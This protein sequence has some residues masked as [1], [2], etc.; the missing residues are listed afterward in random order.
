MEY[1]NYHH[2]RVFWTVVQ[3]GGVTR[4]S[5]KLHVS[6][7]TVTAQIRSLEDALGQKLFK[8]SGRNLLLT[9]TGR[10]VY[11]YAD[12]MVGL[13]Q[14]LLDTV[15][16]QLPGHR[17]RLTVGVAMVVP[18]L[19]AYRVLEPVLKLTE[20]VRVECL[21]DTPERLLAELAV[22]RLDLVLADA[23]VG[24]S[25]SVRAYNHLLGECGVSL[26]GTDPLAAAYRKGFPR[27][28]DGAPFLLP[29][30]NSALRGALDEW[31][32]RE[33]I[34][35]S[36]VGEFEDSALMKTFG[37]AGAGLFPVAL[38]TAA[39]VRRKYGVR[40]VGRAESVRQQFY[41]ITVERKL[42]HPAVVAV[43]AQAARTL[44]T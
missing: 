31:F 42:R 11:R 37:E 25:V 43:V 12:E 29:R 38:P 13:G 33:R 20:A 7:P 6:Q 10:S 15:R 24:P 2:L 5:E 21:E 22:F 17:L 16:G 1:L 27:S 19:I 23:P 3:E 9:D 36:I 35:P 34:R 44:F 14:E 39:A 4:A 18:K 40:E 41:A 32:D 30:R 28:V 26:C 8:R